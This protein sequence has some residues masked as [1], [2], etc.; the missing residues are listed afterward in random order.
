MGSTNLLFR[1][2]ASDAEQSAGDALSRATAVS[3]MVAVQLVATLE[4]FQASFPQCS[5]S[6]AVAIV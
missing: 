3:S 2:L 4:R 6:Q 5:A 1:N